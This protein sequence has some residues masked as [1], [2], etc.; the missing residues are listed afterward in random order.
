[1]AE[2]EKWTVQ[3]VLGWTAA[4]LAVAGAFL[5]PVSYSVARTE[6]VAEQVS[7]LGARFEEHQ[8]EPHPCT[9]RRLQL[10]ESQTL[11]MA[12]QLS[13]IARDVSYLRG[14]A[15]GESAP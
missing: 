2:V 10:L 4:I 14:R 8:L 13:Q 5:G 15:E 12:E 9:E 7:E 6:R 1:M 3:R 11:R